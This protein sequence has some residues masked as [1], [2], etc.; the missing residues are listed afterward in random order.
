MTQHPKP[1]AAQMAKQTHIDL[2]ETAGSLKIP[3]IHDAERGYGLV[4][5]ASSTKLLFW[6]AVVV[7]V[8]V[9][10]GLIGVIV[11]VA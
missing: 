4:D 3:G 11:A 9:I 8:G 10:A 5:P 6:G 7:L 1:T 2:S